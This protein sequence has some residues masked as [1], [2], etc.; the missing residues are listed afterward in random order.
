MT[1]DRFTMSYIEA[2]LWSSMDESEAMDAN[3]A[4]HGR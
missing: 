4:I 1:L 3:Y 2:S